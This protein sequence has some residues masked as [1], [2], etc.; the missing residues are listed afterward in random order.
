MDFL[1]IFDLNL[2]LVLK[3][4]RLHAIKRII[5]LAGMT[6]QTILSQELRYSGTFLCAFVP[7]S[8]SFFHHPYI[9]EL[10]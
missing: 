3:D 9:S 1:Q 2:H 7:L 5:R 10:H 4:S 6:P 8:L